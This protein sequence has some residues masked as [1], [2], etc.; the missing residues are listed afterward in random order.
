MRVLQGLWIVLADAVASS[1]MITPAVAIA[2]SGGLGADL[3]AR[4]GDDVAT[5][6]NELDEYSPSSLAESGA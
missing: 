4:P 2:I 1:S 6:I 5:A 3:A